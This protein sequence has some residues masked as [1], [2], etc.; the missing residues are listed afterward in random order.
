MHIL[1]NIS[2]IKGIQTMKFEY[3]IEYKMENIFL[4][5]L[6]NTAVERL[7]SDLFLFFFNNF[8]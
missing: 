3:I 1:L 8:K 6:G 5:K 2:R 7:V 4:Q